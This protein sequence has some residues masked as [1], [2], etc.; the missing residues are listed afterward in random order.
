MNNS[1]CLSPYT[2]YSKVA[3]L[4]IKPNSFWHCLELFTASSTW[5]QSI[6]IITFLI[7]LVPN[8]TKSA[9]EIIRFSFGRW[10]T[11]C[12]MCSTRWNC[13]ICHTLY[14][15]SAQ[16]SSH[17]RKGFRSHFETKKKHLKIFQFSYKYIIS[18]L[19]KDVFW[20]KKNASK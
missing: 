14:P 9:E 12:K 19:I 20:T 16:G 15:R 13:V 6:S 8:L 4:T 3:I 11:F 10:R 7:P 17:L 18:E 5:L 1:I 2:T